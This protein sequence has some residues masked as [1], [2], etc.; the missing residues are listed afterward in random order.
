MSDLVGEVKG[1]LLGVRVLDMTTLLPGPFASQILTSLGATVVKVEPPGGDL[2]RTLAPATFA[3]VNRGKRSVVLDL[4]SED[5]LAT[6]RALVRGADVLIENFRPGVMNRLGF[7]VKTVE[8]LRPGIV[9]LSLSGWGQ[10]GPSAQFPGHDGNYLARTGATYLSATR[11]QLPTDVNPISIADLAGSLYGVIGILSALLRPESRTA[12]KL[13]VSLFSSALSLMM[14]RLAE[15]GAH[16]G[17]PTGDELMRRRAGRGVY[18]AQDGG[19]LVLAAV[20]DHFWVRLCEAIDR[21]DLA[22]RPDL[23]SNEQ[24]SARFD[25]V[26]EALRSAIARHPRETWLRRMRDFDVP[27]SAVLEPWEVHGDDQVRHLGVMSEWPEGIAAFVPITGLA[28]TE[29]APDSPLLDADGERIRN[30]GW[31]D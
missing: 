22:E 27:A 8:A 17:R 6:M 25:E 12:T 16:G 5:G 11:G 7:D 3:A 26:D 31:P 1:P 15:Y 9:N 10:H 24:R 2:M 20:E 13:D 4:K 21:P 18:E 19:L 30:Q 28:L 14:P 29:T 23:R